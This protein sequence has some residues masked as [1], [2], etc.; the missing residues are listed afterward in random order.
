MAD[1][2]GSG[3]SRVT[4]PVFTRM[5]KKDAEANLENLKKVLEARG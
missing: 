1:T 5:L 4:E 2:H 3:L